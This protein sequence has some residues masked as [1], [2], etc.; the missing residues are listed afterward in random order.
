MGKKNHVIKRGMGALLTAAMTL[1]ALPNMNVYA[2]PEQSREPVLAIDAEMARKE[3]L[4]PEGEPVPVYR[5]VK[6]GDASKWGYQAMVWVDEDGNEVEGKSFYDEPALYRMKDA[7]PSSYS[8]AGKGELP[9]VRNQGQWGTCWAHAAIASVET[10]MVKKGLIDVSDADYSERH[11]SYF[12]H[13]RNEALGDGE[14]SFSDDYGW[15]GGGNYYQALAVLSNWNGAADE[16][17]YPY[18]SY[19]NMDDLAESDRMASVSHVTDAD[20]LNTAEDVKRAVMDMGAV[21]CSFYTGDG[22]V[23]SAQEF[24]YHANEHNIDHSVNIVGWD[25]NYEK[26]VFDDNGQQPK[27]NGAW[28]CRNSW[29]ENWAQ[30]GYFWISYED[31]TIGEFCSFQAE[32]ADNYDH[33]YSYDG[34]MALA[35]IPYGKSANIFC[36]SETEELK[37]VSFSSDKNYDYLIEIYADR[38]GT[39]KVP[40]DGILVCSQEGSLSYPGYHTVSLEQGVILDAGTKYAVSVQFIPKNGEGTANTYLETTEHGGN[41]SSDPG[42]S[43]FYIGSEWKATENL[44]SGFKNICVKAFTNDVESVDEARILSLI[45]EAEGLVESDYTVKS[46]EALQ[47]AITG[48]RRAVS[49]DMSNS[50]KIRALLD[51]QSAKTLLAP[52]GVYISTEDELERLSASVASGNNYEGQTVY[53]LNDLDMTGIT[54]TMIGNGSAPFQG[55][56]DGGGHEIANLTYEFNYSYGGLFGYIGENGIVKNVMLTD[57]DMTFGHIYSG[58][59]AGFNKGTV[60]GCAIQGKFTFEHGYSGGIAGVNEGTV[61]ACGITGNIHLNYNSSQIGGAIGDNRGTVENVAV[62][63]T[64]TFQNQ[65]ENSCFVGGIAGSNSGIIAKCSMEGEI[66]AGSNASVGGIVGFSEEGSAV[67]L[68]RNLASISG[69]PASDSRTA[70]IGVCLYGE[71]YGCYNYGTITRASGGSD[72]TGAVYCYVR[73]GT[74]ANCYYLETDSMGGSYDR[75]FSITSMTEAE[76]ASGKAAYYLNSGGGEEENK[77]EWSQ[78]DGV[79]VCSD[80]ENPAVIKVTVS[81]AAGNEC[82]V[83]VNGVTDGEFYA[84]GGTLAGISFGSHTPPPGYELAAEITGLSP[85]DEDNIFMLPDHDTAVTAF[86]RQSPVT[87]NITC[88]LRGGSGATPASY[89]I[90]TPV[91]LPVPQRGSIEFLGWYDNAQFGG[92]PVSEIPIGTTGDKEYWA[93]WEKPGFEVIFPQKKGYEAVTAGE[94]ENGDIPENGSYCFTVRAAKGYDVSNIVIKRGGAALEASLDG[95]YVIDNIVAD[96]NDISVEGIKLSSGN[97]EIESAKGYVAAATVIRPKLPASKIRLA[98][99]EE[100]ADS[101]TVATDQEVSVVTCDDGETCSDMEIVSFQSFGRDVTSPGI[102]SVEVIPENMEGVSRGVFLVIDASDEESGVSEYSFDGGSTWQASGGYYVACEEEESVFSGRIMVRDYVGNITEYTENVTIPAAEKYGSIIELGAGKESY[103]YGEQVI[104]GVRVVFLGDADEVQLPCGRVRFLAEDG[105]EIGVA[106]LEEADDFSFE[107]VTYHSGAARIVLRP[108][109]YGSVGEKRFKAVFDGKGTPYQNNETE[110][111][112]T[113]EQA[114]IISP[115][116]EDIEVEMGSS[117]AAGAAE[118]GEGALPTSGQVFAGG[119][120]ISYK[121]LWNAKQAIDLTAAG[122]C[123][124]FVGT[125]RYLNVPEWAKEPESLEVRRKVTVRKTQGKNPPQDHED[126]FKKGAE[127]ISKNGRYQ[128]FDAKKKTAILVAVKNKKATRFEVPDTVKICGTKCKVVE[129]KANVFKG[130][131]KLKKLVLGKN[132]V[133]IGKQ[134]FMNCKKLRTIQLKG[135]ALKTIGSKAFQKTAKKVTVKTS[136][137]TKKQKESLLKKLKKAGIHI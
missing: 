60:S 18:A 74:I 56:F 136:K 55:I 30:G 16:K 51:L 121:I 86:G 137:L 94:S 53:L 96:I 28:L 35:G 43:F 19:G 131:S 65:Q 27:N 52:A 113:I 123:V 125:V 90:E 39:M 61:S 58:G 12:A 129:I 120:A 54:H 93:K 104:L 49:E 71:T 81:Q 23:N 7:L 57:A 21:M 11:L 36:A 111:C 17:D 107:G 5:L 59:I 40:S 29:G 116:F 100:F 84:N 22:T 38:D 41:Y 8:M 101:L 69:S 9:A 132:V 10:N 73:N 46:W 48:A 85:T 106:E 95:K 99:E 66:I 75:V 26:T 117:H 114:A 105:T 25:D 77:R 87:Y 68:C 102:Q 31:A 32:G 14:D 3:V 1:G 64:V 92:E 110:E 76:F 47:A 37:A 45:A 115:V 2:M 122:S 112:V 118:L 98:S 78:K 34:A 33:I 89:N 50:G 42:Q 88:H 72:E 15:Y 134:A 44:N 13:R 79:P 62:N 80:D 83:L 67:R 126:K 108:S 70:G 97:Y 63:G 103:T 119:S 91:T 6:K 4:T 20:F 133:K 135:K 82:P 124:E 109:V 127:T 128:V 24:V 130:G